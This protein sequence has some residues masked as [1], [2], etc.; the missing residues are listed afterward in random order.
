MV[1]HTCNRAVINQFSGSTDPLQQSQS[2]QTASLHE[3]QRHFDTH[4]FFFHA[5]SWQY[6]LCAQV[7]CCRA[8]CVTLCL[9][10]KRGRAQGCAGSC[11]GLFWLSHPCDSTLLW[12]IIWTWFFISRTVHVSRTSQFAD[13]A[14]LLELKIWPNFS[15][16]YYRYTSLEAAA[17]R[18]DEPQRHG[19]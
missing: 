11:Y 10:G 14:L 6:F 16:I 19:R 4:Q 7:E 12:S 2:K 9:A 15:M 1:L 3:F 13:S 5:A 18:A 17:Y 8:R